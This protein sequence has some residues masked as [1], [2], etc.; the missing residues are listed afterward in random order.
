LD[1]DDFYFEDGSNNK[2]YVDDVTY[3]SAKDELTFIM[4]DEFPTDVAGIT[5]KLATTVAT[6]NVFE[7]AIDLAA[8]LP[9]LVDEIKPEVTV[10]DAVYA[11]AGKD[12]LATFVLGQN[13]GAEGVYVVLEA[14]EAIDVP[15]GADAQALL[16]DAFT[17]KKG[18]KELAINKVFEYTGSGTEEYDKNGVDYVVLFITADEDGNAVNENWIEDEL[19]ITFEEI[20][21]KALTITDAASNDNVLAGFENEKVEI[22]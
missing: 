17:V 4:D 11:T 21:V 12:G 20:S 18:T 7:Q 14:S 3:D 22:Q 6:E 15:A 8:G 1:A 2:Y 5:L 13:A 9:G 19:T 16:K 10:T